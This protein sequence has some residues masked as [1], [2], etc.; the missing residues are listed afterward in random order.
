MKTT[1]NND[2]NENASTTEVWD[3]AKYDQIEAD[4][5]ADYDDWQAGIAA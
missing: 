4:R 5:A 3:Q 2:A 1:K